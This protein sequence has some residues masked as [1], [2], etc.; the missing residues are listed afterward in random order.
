MTLSRGALA[1]CAATTR[2]GRAHTKCCAQAVRPPSAAACVVSRP[3][4]S[5]EASSRT[6]IPCAAAAVA[7]ASAKH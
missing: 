6:S 4:R 2:R 7:G 3:S 5:G 1:T